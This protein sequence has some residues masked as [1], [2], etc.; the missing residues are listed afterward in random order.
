MPYN[1]LYLNKGNN[2]SVK[3]SILTKLIGYPEFMVLIICTKNELNLI[4]RY[5]DMVPDRQKVRT[6]GRTDG[7]N[8]RTHGRRQN[9]IPP[10]S[11]GDNY[12]VSK[13]CTWVKV[14]RIKPEIRILKLTFHRKSTSICWIREIR[15]ASLIIIFVGIMQIFESL[16]FR[17]YVKDKFRL[18]DQQCGPRSGCSL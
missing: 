16:K 4:N 8:G 11:S 13:W 3:G 10:T 1:C 6:D 18:T 12:Q 17:I 14:L 9:Y 7:R 5:W 15:I 2:S